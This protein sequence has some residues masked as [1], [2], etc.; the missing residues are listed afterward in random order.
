MTN[1]TRRQGS[2]G[3]IRAVIELQRIE[4][5]PEHAAE[6]LRMTRQAWEILRRKQGCLV[7]HLYHSLAEPERWLSYSE[8]SSLAEL[9]G[10]RRELARSPLYRRWHSA[11]KSSSERAYEPF[12]TIHSIR[13]DGLGPPTTAVLVT[14]GRGA[15]KPK[16]P[17]SFLA[18]LAGYLSHILMRDL[19]E[20]GALLC[21]AHF[22]APEQAAA[23]PA[24]IG[25]H[26]AARELRP[27]VELFAS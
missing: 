2:P 12:G 14:M 13:G 3:R 22:A 26:E 15:Q 7:Q 27:A 23:A 1:V 6:A 20:P 25:E 17:L 10:A 4:L 8:W 11:M 16:D 9:G 18:Q 21:L 5:K 24:A 19:A